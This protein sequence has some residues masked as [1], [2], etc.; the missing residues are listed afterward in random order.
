MVCN[1]CGYDESKDNT[2]EFVGIF[3]NGIQLFTTEGNVCGIYGCPV[4][5]TIQFTTDANYIEKRKSKYKEKRKA[6]N[7][8]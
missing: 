7:N 4:C 1:Q 2:T 3:S 6:G 8:R 5:K